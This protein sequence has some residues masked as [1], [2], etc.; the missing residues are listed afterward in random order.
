MKRDRSMRTVCFAAAAS[1]ALVATAPATWA[2]GSFDDAIV[3]IE[4]NATDGDAGD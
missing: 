4:I 1:L 3:L 2:Q